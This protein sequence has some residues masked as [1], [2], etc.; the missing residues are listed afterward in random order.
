MLDNV[1]TYFI[2]NAPPELQELNIVQAKRS[3]GLGAMG[4][5]AYLQRHNVPFESPMAKGRNMAMF[6]HIKSAA[7]VAS[8]QLARE[9]GS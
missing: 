7:E 8:E 1:L 2:E 4:F 3:I 5:H 9:R 6:W